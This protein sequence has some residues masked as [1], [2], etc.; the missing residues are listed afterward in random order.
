MTKKPKIELYPIAKVEHY[1]FGKVTRTWWEVQ[2]P[3]GAIVSCGTYQDALDAQE[4]K[5]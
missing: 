3:D 5:T 4:R 2:H 1:E